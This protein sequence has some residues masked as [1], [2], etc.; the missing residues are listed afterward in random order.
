MGSAS[1]ISPASP[2]DHGVTLNPSSAKRI[3]VVR[4]P[5]TLLYGANAIGGLVNVITDQIPTVPIA[6]HVRRADA[7]PGQQRRRGRRRGRHALRPR[8]PGRARRRRRRGA[9]ANFRRRTATSRTRSRA[10][11]CSTSAPRWT[12]DRRYVGASY[13]FDDSRYGIP[14]VEDGP[15]SL[16]PQRHAVTIRAGG[17]GLAGWLSSYRATLRGAPLRARRARGRARSARTSTTT[18]R[19]PSCWCRI[20]RRQAVGHRR[21]LVPESR[22]QRRGAEALAPPIDQRGAAA[23]PLRRADVAAR[24]V[25]VRRTIRPHAVSRQTA[26]LPARDFNEFSGS[27]GLLVRP[28]AANDNFVIALSL[29]RAARNPA[30][31]ELYFFGAHPGNFAFEI[32]NPRSRLGARASASTCRC[33]PAR[34]ACAARSPCSPTRSTISSSATRSQREEFADREAEFDARFGVTDDEGGGHAHEDEF[35]FVEFSGADSR[36]SGRRGA[37]RRQPDGAPGRR[38][39][40]RLGAR[41]VVATAAS[42]CRGFRRS[43]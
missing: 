27:I 4:G 16:N 22:V 26:V 3:E 13:G 36:L 28:A 41:H 18:P 33:A 17:E 29:A 1:A 19:R 37:R 35:P 12:T 30:L 43:A 9:T 6:R 39:H 15:I 38:G 34:R 24:H 31:E 5:A 7:R 8:A 23:V 32:G 25:P 2:G 14:I 42:R 10:A 40:L 21:R 20:G 11:A